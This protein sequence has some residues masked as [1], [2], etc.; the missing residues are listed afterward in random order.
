MPPADYPIFG[1]TMDIMSP[2][3]CNKGSLGEGVYFVESLRLL[4]C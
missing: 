2:Y 1:E 3:T 4:N